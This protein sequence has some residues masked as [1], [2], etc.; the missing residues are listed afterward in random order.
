ML[1]LSGELGGI[2]NLPIC[3]YEQ[4]ILKDKRTFCVALVQKLIDLFVFFKMEG[5]ASPLQRSTA[6]ND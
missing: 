6:M 2:L 5:M 1:G 3:S 4:Q